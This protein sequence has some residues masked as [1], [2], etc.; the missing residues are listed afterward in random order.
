MWP[1]GDWLWFGDAYRISHRDR[2]RGDYN[3]VPFGITDGAQALINM[4]SPNIR[5]GFKPDPGPIN[6]FTLTG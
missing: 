3:A 1:L 4:S 5:F 2:I 6:Y